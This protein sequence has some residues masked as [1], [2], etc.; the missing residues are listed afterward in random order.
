[1][2]NPIALVLLGGEIANEAAAI[3]YAS[4][5][6]IVLCADSGAE[7]ARRLGLTI[8]AIIGD[9][10][11]ISSETLEFYRGQGV[12]IEL[13]QEQE[14]NDFEKTLLHLSRNFSGDVRVFGMTGKRTDHTMTN[15]SVM[16][17][18]TDRF[19]SIIALDNFAEYRFLTSQHNR[20]VLGCPIGTTI[21][22]IPFGEA[23]G[24]RTENLQY[25]LWGEKLR[26][27]ERE[28]LSNVATG[29]PVSIEI[30]SGALLIIVSTEKTK[31][32]Q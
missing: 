16:L 5:A 20:C 25:P 27:G 22:L 15:L 31:S 13:T 9:L 4:A 21:S 19:E 12:E 24:I 14:G 3:H 7:H 10:D 8:T 1:V 32:P 23:E 2:A 28:G 6:A 29:T 26:L 11:S 18:F 17:R 30:A